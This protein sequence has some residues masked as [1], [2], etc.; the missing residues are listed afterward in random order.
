MEALVQVA[1]AELQCQLGLLVRPV[2]VELLQMWPE[3]LQITKQAWHWN[4]THVLK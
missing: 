1:Q 3:P 2:Q 4:Q